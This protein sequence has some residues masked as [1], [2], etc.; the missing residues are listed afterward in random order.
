[1]ELEFIVSKYG[2]Y[3]GGI[4]VER[5]LDSLRRDDSGEAVKRVLGLDQLDVGDGESAECLKAKA[6]L[7]YYTSELARLR[8]LYGELRS[9]GVS[10][11]DLTTLVRR[12]QEA[13]RLAR[14]YRDILK[15]CSPQVSDISP[16][17]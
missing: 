3:L 2:R 11:S 6:F 1:M 7:D 14:F 10:P 8:S 5:V 16:Q 12:M 13:R 9:G 17:R 4:S 15:R